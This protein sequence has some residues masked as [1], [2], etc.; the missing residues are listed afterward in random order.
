MEKEVKKRMKSKYV[1]RN[2]R[3]KR[4]EKLH[5]RNHVKQCFKKKV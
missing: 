4:I 1:K 2:I 3:L 5:D